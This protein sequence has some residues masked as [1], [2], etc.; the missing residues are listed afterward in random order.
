MFV[1]DANGAWAFDPDHEADPGKQAKAEVDYGPGNADEHCSICQYWI[2][3]DACAKVEGEIRAG[4]WCKLFARHQGRHDAVEEPEPEYVPDPRGNELDIA[5]ALAEE[6]LPSPQQ[7][8]NMWLFVMR[9]T[10]TGASYRPEFQEH[11]WRDAGYYL[12]PDF[13]ARIGGLFVIWEHPPGDVL[14][15]PEFEKRVI[16]SVM[17]PFI[18]EDEVWAVVRVMAQDAAQ[19]MRDTQLSTSPA[20]TLPPGKSQ[21]RKLESG[22]TL[23]IESVPSLVDHLAVCEAGVWD[24]GGEPTGI[25]IGEPE[26]AEGPSEETPVVRLDRIGSAI[27]EL[28]GV[29]NRL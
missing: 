24:K 26:I 7:Y 5:R 25:A 4:D 11:V 3:P 10:G 20:V 28:S 22:R 14:T 19:L 17:L 23:I 12:T 29:I 18:K 2:E 1:R 13:L 15:Q 27:D 9:V 21:M 16:G 6:R 8:E